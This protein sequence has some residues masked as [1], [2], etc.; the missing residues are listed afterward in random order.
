MY[1]K[2]RQ[3]SHNIF[4]YKIYFNTLYFIINIIYPTNSKANTLIMVEFEEPTDSTVQR[5]QMLQSRKKQRLLTTPKAKI[6]EQEIIR[7]TTGTETIKT[8]TE[9]MQKYLKGKQSL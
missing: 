5:K 1:I 7:V 3:L 2:I 6:R 8:K 4:Y 9:Q